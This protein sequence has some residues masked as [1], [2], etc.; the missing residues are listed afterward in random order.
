MAPRGSQRKRPLRN[1]L[2]ES[3][4]VVPPKR[5]FTNSKGRP[6]DWLL[7]TK[8]IGIG[9]ATTALKRGLASKEFVKR[10][11]AQMAQLNQAAGEVF[12]SR[13]FKVNALTE[14]KGL[15]LLGHVLELAR[16]SS[17]AAVLELEHLPI[18][19]GV[20]AL[21]EQDIVPDRTKANLTQVEPNVAF[22][23]GLPMPIR[24][25]LADAQTNGGLLA[26]VPNRDLDRALKGLARAKVEIW[27]IGRL[28]KGRPE[29]HVV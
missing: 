13:A 12:A 26:A 22:P 28:I 14:V 24:Y 4:S 6:G 18:L 29:I 7:L 2:T 3:T 27:V 11:T 20:P 15:G 8:P 21:A 19:A 17:V 10:V 9:I 5:R 1:K 23:E 25:V 16:G